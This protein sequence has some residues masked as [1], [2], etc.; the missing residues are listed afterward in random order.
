MPIE[1]RRLLFSSDELAEALIAFNGH[2]KTKFLEPGRLDGITLTSGDEVIAAKVALTGEDG[3]S[4][5]VDLDETVIGAAIIRFC[6]DHQV[7]LPIKAGKC[8]GIVDGQVALDITKPPRTRKATR[9]AAAAA[10]Q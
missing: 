4:R 8:L 7:P 5:A 1:V 9:A 3:K 10:A 2:A 6:R